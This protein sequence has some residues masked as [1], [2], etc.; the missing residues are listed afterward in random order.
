M[1]R[2]G[3]L[4]LSE[5]KRILRRYWW[6]L[7]ATTI[8]AASVG[9]GLALVLPKKY[10][11]S[12]NVLVEPPT[13]SP[14]VVK[15]LITE[16]LYHRLASMKEQTLSRSRL[17]PI[18]EKL[19]LYPDLRGKKH[20]EELVDRLRESIDVALMEPMAGSVDRQPPGFH[21]SV[22]FTDPQLAQQIC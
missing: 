2:N 7:P 9:V 15:G 12:T 16:D 11:S 5:I 21:V 3:E 19:N 8:L 18:I 20:M 13:V 10:T 1:L 22:T 4:N 17:Q 14:E 6:L